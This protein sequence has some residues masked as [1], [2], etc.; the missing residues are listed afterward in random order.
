MSDAAASS[1]RAGAAGHRGLGGG[2]VGLIQGS[3]YVH[4]AIDTI[5]CALSEGLFHPFPAL[6]V[7]VLPTLVNVGTGRVTKVP[8][9]VYTGRVEREPPV[10]KV[11]GGQAAADV[12]EAG[13]LPA[14]APPV[15]QGARGGLQGDIFPHVPI[16]VRGSVGIQPFSR[17]S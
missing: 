1:L 5:I 16:A 17:P 13:M 12:A 6:T 9:G 4:P 3:R 8:V 2:V 15:C 7:A 11:A 14:P 10:L